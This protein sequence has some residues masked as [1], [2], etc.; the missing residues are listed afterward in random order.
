[1]FTGLGI[2]DAG[3]GVG[4]KTEGDVGLPDT[5]LDNGTDAVAVLS[6][7]EVTI[8]YDGIAGANR[9]AGLPDA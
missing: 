3:E 8:E 5:G 4:I 6:Y 9:V 7:A 2:W 1:L